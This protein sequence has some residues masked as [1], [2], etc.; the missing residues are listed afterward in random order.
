MGATQQAEQNGRIE[1][2]NA[3]F[4]RLQRSMNLTHRLM[5]AML[6]LLTALN[7]VFIAS[8]FVR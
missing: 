8:I 3:R 2:T 1:Q 5:V 7:A 6:G 4:D